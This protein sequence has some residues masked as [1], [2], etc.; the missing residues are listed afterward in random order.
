MSTLEPELQEEKKEETL[1]KKPKA[2]KPKAPKPKKVKWNVPAAKS[3]IRSTHWARHIH[4]MIKEADPSLLLRDD[5]RDAYN[6][7]VECLV[8]HRDNV[9][10]HAPYSY[11]KYR[12]G[13]KFNTLEEFQMSRTILTL[14]HAQLRITTDQYKSIVAA[15]YQAYEP[16][17]LL[18]KDTVVSYMEQT[19][20]QKKRKEDE[21]RYKRTLTKLLEQQMSMIQKYQTSMSYLQREIDVCNRGL[22]ALSE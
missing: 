22:A 8:L 6:Q 20:L 12:Q 10:S 3:V 13:I 19:L 21:E 11:V 7:L 2:L 15:I 1:S 17:Y 9:Q 5:I 4:A 16:L 14:Q 18:I